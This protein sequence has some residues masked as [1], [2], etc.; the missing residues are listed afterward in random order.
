MS[1]LLQNLGIFIAIKLAYQSFLGKVG[2]HE[3]WHQEMETEDKNF[4]FVY[5][6]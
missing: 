4:K 6:Y 2:K 3:S 1:L 5:Y